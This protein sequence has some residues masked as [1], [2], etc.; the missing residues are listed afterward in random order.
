MA[1]YSADWSIARFLKKD[2]L[3]GNRW[4]LDLYPE[5]MVET[6]SSRHNNKNNNNNN[7]D[8]AS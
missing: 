6:L 4:F 7:D 3:A 2:K 1:W 8:L 5:F